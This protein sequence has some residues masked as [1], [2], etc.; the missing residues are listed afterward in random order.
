[1]Q[2]RARKRLDPE[3][4]LVRQIRSQ[5]PT[6]KDFDPNVENPDPHWEQTL[7]AEMSDCE[8]TYNL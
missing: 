2:T 4:K 1:M 3:V 7:D 5:K 6:P 8:R